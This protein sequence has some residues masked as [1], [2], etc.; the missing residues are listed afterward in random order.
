MKKILAA[1]VAMGLVGL[2]HAAVASGTLDV[3][4]TV[5]PACTVSTPSNA[6]SFPVY[7]PTGAAVTATTDIG[8]TCNLGQIYTIALGNGLNF[9][10]NRRMSDGQGNFLEYTI[11]RPDNTTNAATV[12]AWGGANVVSRTGTGT[13]TIATA[14]GTVPSNANNQAA[15]SGNYTDTVAITVTY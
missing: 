6:M 5:A 1:A 12:T 8:V 9:L 11:N 10:V 3:S 2:T 7:N 13:E 14:Y 4:A 15:V